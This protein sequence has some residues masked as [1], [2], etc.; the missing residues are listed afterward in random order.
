M[1]ESAAQA[2]ADAH[3]RISGTTSRLISGLIG[4]DPEDADYAEILGTRYIRGLAMLNDR[5]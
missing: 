5:S 1:R 3:K 2:H 4:T